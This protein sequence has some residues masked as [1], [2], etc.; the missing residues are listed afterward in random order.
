[1]SAPRRPGFP[2]PSF[3][4]SAGLRSTDLRDNLCYF[5]AGIQWSSLSLGRK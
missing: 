3:L 1:V 2:A 5:L 4:L